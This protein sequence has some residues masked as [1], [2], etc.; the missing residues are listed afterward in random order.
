MGLTKKENK[1]IF[2]EEQSVAV[3]SFLYKGKR[4]QLM[5]VDKKMHQQTASSS[6]RGRGG[7]YS[8]IEVTG[9]FF[10]SLRGANRRF[11]SHLGCL[12]WKVTI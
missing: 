12:G 10:F 3:F 4:V 7:G 2:L 11:W 1:Y 5:D 8:L 9:M 6:G